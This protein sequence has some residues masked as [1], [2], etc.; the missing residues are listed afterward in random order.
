MNNELLPAQF[1]KVSNAILGG[2][3]NCNYK[4]YETR[5]TTKSINNKEHN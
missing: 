4:D 5:P 3:E 1:R 2:D